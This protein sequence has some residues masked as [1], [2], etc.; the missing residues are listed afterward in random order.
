[1]H[2]PKPKHAG[3][4]MGHLSIAD[5]NN[6][7]NDISAGTRNIVQIFREFSDAFSI[8]REDLSNSRTGQPGSYGGSALSSLYA[9]NYSSFEKARSHLKRLYTER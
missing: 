8:L 9:G 2:F 5:P 6:P 3:Q 4:K 7:S 1:M